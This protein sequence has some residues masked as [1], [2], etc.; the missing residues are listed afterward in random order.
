M[1]GMASKRVHVQVGDRELSLSNLDKVLYPQAGF[2]KAQVVDYYSRIAPVIVPH[3]R[4]RPLTLKRF[5]DGVDG[6][7]FFSKNCASHRPSWIQTAKVWS[8]QNHRWQDY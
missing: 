6:E 1:T 2:T 4:D 8:G 7:S 3:L 5:P